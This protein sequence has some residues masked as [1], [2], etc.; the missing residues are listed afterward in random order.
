MTYK[1]AGEID[2][3]NGER[4]NEVKEDCLIDLSQIPVLRKACGSDYLS[5]KGGCVGIPAR[6]KYFGT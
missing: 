4:S 6:V 1:H 3:E 2:E 5:C